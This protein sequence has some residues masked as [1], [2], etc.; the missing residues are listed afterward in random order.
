MASARAERTAAILLARRATLQKRRRRT[1]LPRQIPPR[2]LEREYAKELVGIVA[3]VKREL[4]PLLAAL[5]SLTAQAAAEREHADSH[6]DHKLVASR[7]D[8]GE[9]RRAQ[10]LIDETAERLRRAIKPEVLETFARRVGERV[11]DYQRV[12]LDRQVKAAL[13]ADVFIADRKLRARLDG[14]AAENVALIKDLPPKIIGDVE[15]ATTRAIQNGTLHRDLATELNEKFGFGE[16]RAK[17]IARDQV[18]RLYAQVNHDRQRELGIER[19]RWVT[20]HDERVRDEHAELDGQ[21]FRYDD[22]PSEGLPGEPIQCRCIAEPIFDELLSAV[23]D[24]EE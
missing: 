14:F 12:Q 11:S 5:P 24:L 10:E 8:E 7:A 22:P 9:G 4:G 1:R 13:G 6:V 15:K 20:V 23:E 18:G 17:L 16:N 21:I 19:F 3:L 2:P